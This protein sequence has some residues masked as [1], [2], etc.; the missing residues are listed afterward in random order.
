MVDIIYLKDI[1]NNTDL[2]DKEI[3]PDIEE[4]HEDIIGADTRN[5]LLENLKN[6]AAVCTAKAGVDAW[7]GS[8]EGRT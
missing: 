2:D 1:K 8:W 3:A 4:T 5:E 6:E 7:F